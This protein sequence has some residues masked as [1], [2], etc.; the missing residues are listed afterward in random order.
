MVTLSGPVYTARDA[1]HRLLIECLERGGEP[2]IPIAGETIYY[3]GPAPAK[4][5][6]P[7]GPA[8]PTTSYRMDAHAP[9]LIRLG[10]NGMIGKGKRGPKVVEAMKRHGA[11]Y[12]GAVGGAAAFLMKRITSC[13]P[14]AYEFL[15]SEAIFRLTLEDFPVTVL[16]DSYGNNAYDEGPAAYKKFIEANT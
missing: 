9:E 11:V 8:G 14:V 7:I 5:G 2:P 12:F 10:L 4:P 13:E 15:Q 6:M 3:V 16:I 1:A